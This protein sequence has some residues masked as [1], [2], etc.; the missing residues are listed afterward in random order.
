M[1]LTYVELDEN[2]ERSS[3]QRGYGSMDNCGDAINNPGKPGRVDEVTGVLFVCEQRRR[4][5]RRRHAR[6]GRAAGGEEA[7]RE[8]AGTV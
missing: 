4:T 1:E 7:P 8:G 6:E 2:N 3:R 5:A